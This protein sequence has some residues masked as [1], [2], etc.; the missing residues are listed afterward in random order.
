MHRAASGAGAA[1]RPRRG[2]TEENAAR[3]RPAWLR[4]AARDRSSRGPTADRTRPGPGNCSTRWSSGKAE[5]RRGPIPLTS[6]ALREAH[7]ARFALRRA[8]YGR[9]PDLDAA[10]VGAG[11]ARATRDLADREHTI[12]VLPSTLF[13]PAPG[14]CCPSSRITR[15][16]SC[17][18]S[19]WATA[20]AKTGG[21]RLRSSPDLALAR[22]KRRSR[23]SRRCMMTRAL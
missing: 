4:L 15:S 1:G 11:A 14:A 20:T 3:G 19:P 17:C 8:A 7:F 16:P 2:G 10:P 22:A 23:P 13:S 18:L 12:V 9:I 21:M 5:F 6:E